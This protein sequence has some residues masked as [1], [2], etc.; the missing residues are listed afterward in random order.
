[1]GDPEARGRWRR[2]FYDRELAGV[3]RATVGGQL[4][5]CND[6]MARML[7]YDA[8][9]EL[10]A[11]PIDQLYL[12]D[13]G[14]HLARLRAE[15]HVSGG[16]ARLRHREGR[17]VFAVYSERL[18]ED[19]QG[20]EIVEGAL[21]DVTA[22]RLQGALRS[23]DAQLLG[24]VAGGVSVRLVEPLAYVAANVGFAAEH[25]ASLPPSPGVDEIRRALEDAR[26]GAEAIRRL[27]RDLA[28]FAGS[29]GAPRT[30]AC[31]LA[32]SALSLLEPMIAG[33]AR[34]V[35]EL[36][37]GVAS[38]ADEAIVGRAL[39]QLLFDAAGSMSDPA[40]D[41]RLR[42]SVRRTADGRG[43]VEIED[44]GH[45]GP[46]AQAE[47]SP[48][49]VAARAALASVGASVASIPQGERGRIL[50]ILLPPVR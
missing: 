17:T 13:R 7:G 5:E 47:S 35:R 48:A 34:V 39:L 2:R 8:L 38:S 43:L 19:A 23:A 18:A 10:L 32:D 26:A 14:A 22:R 12:D 20:R 24:A 21:I 9:E 15:G 40:P 44:T 6:A 49:L 37:D 11:I 25:L 33:R 45:H 42:M 3:Y 50:R 28:A 29:R 41:Q 31:R 36:E 16:E 4:L 1:M 46:A 27:G 30:D